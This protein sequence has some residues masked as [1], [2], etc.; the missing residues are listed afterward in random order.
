M[1]AEMQTASG[2][3]DRSLQA[4]TLQTLAGRLGTLD[5]FRAVIASL[6]SGEGASLEGVWG[7]LCALAA[8]AV[9]QAAP[10]TLL[11]LCPTPQ[12]AEKIC[13]DLPLFA[14][15]ESARF[16]PA[17]SEPGER[18]LDDEI[19]GDRLR[20]VKRLASERPPKLL[21]T[22]IA[23]L[24][25]PVPDRAALDACT[26]RLAVGESLDLAEAAR[27]LTEQGFHATTAVELPGEFSLRG[28]LLDVLAVDWDAPV[29]IELFGDEIAS[30]RQFDIATQRSLQSLESVEITVLPRL[31]VRREHLAAYLPAGSWL[32][33]VDPVETE[34]EGV[35]FLERLDRPQDMHSVRAVL[36]SLHDAPCVVAENVSSSPRE[37]YFRLPV[38]SVERYRGDVAKVREALDECRG[39]QRISVVCQTE[40]EAARLG[41]LFRDTAP[42][43]EGRLGFAI[44]MLHGGFR[45]HFE[46]NRFSIG[47]GE[48]EP[49]AA[50][51]TPALSQ[52]E[53][54]VRRQTLSENALSEKADAAKD[55][56]ARETGSNGRLDDEDLIVLSANELF[57]RADLVRTSRR[58]LGR[59]IDSF[60]ALREGDL[61]VH[62]A[63]GIG[64]YRGLKLLHPAAAQDSAQV[65]EHLEIEFAKGTRI[66]VPAA[67]IDLVQ[68]YI[69]GS[70]GRAALAK[71][72]G[73]L[74][75][76]QKQA[77]QRAVT[78]LAQEML[79]LQAV[80]A[81]LPGIAYPDDSLWQQEFDA[82]FPYQET[83][84]QLTAI[85]DI[86]RD[87]QEA[88]PMDRLLCGDVG[89]GK[90][91][92]AIRAAF[93]A[94]DAGYQVAVLA[95]TTILVEQHLRTFRERMAEFPFEIASL[96]RFSTKGQQKET[97]SRLAKGAVD[98]VIGTHRLA[99]KDVGFHNLGLVV[100]DE[101]QRFGVE[102]KERLKTLRTLVDVLTM[103]ATPIPRT[104][105]LSLLGARSISNLETPPE[106]RIPVETRVARFNEDLIRHAM[107]RELNRGGQIFFVH[108]RVHDIANIAARVGRIAPEA[109]V[110][111][112]HGQMAESQLEEVMLRFVDHQFDVLV[113]TTIIESGL[114]IANANTIFIDGADMYGLAD[115][116]QL[117]GR[118]GRYKHRAYCYLLVDEH[119]H[120]TTEAARRLRAIEEF[121]EMGAGFEIAMRDLELRGA[122][123]ILGAQQSGHIANVG[124]ELYCAL[125]EKTVR[126]LQ[127]LPPRDSIDVHVD[128]PGQAYLP[129]DYVPDMRMKIDLYRR[130]ARLSSLDSLAEFSAELRDRFGP[131]PAV[132]E[133]LVELAEVRI[134]AHA[135]RIQ[136]IHL[137]DEYIVFA[138]AAGSGLAKLGVRTTKGIRPVNEQTAYLPVGEEL[139]TPSALLPWLK[140]LLQPL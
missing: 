17:E 7:S 104:L 79:Q 51:L 93:K 112:G 53:R 6:A 71:I 101:E 97:L 23:G 108:N 135:W 128:I 55:L 134:L 70:R 68:K 33:L 111:I 58:R 99:Q 117:R 138:H 20:I 34:Q 82:S 107:L 29:R 13:D 129:D 119:K 106:D 77:A 100:I 81:S 8:A 43:A 127:K 63:H 74:W 45:I 85:A 98:I 103:T 140:S 62:L 118:V 73:A 21:A 80:R 72:G 137:E 2:S 123:N 26:R 16:P 59:A 109:R 89:Y 38:D 139:R 40:A 114:D 87:M 84:D 19:E 75:Q 61:V 24:V 92:L 54:E 110:A 11:V 18:P 94:V 3:L 88:R 126:R 48:G 52:R 102:V 32:M 90:T 31:G 113:A 4:P 28:G 130:L 131:I 36:E 15:L 116:H 35:R 42:G 125:L 39:D 95:P 22:S 57:E 10:A 49:G 64:R 5:G 78:D 66:Y 86:K 41:Q 37:T 122:G 132:T 133:R 46:A 96:S 1:T 91:E 50:A 44:G 124:Y 83:P 30:L 47:R 105:H 65:E 60:L 14:A 27:W 136:G 9:A 12:D 69:G 115:L 67:K 56:S 121:R 76:K 25:Q 120:L